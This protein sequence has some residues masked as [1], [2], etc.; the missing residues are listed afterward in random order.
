MRRSD[1]DEY[2]TPHAHEVGRTP[3]GGPRGAARVPV[4][5]QTL[6]VAAVGV[7][8]AVGLTG[9]IA[10]VRGAGRHPEAAVTAFL[11][12]QTAGDFAA[13][14]LLLSA[15]DRDQPRTAAGWRF[16]HLCTSPT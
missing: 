14:Y 16:A 11:D 4:A 5:V 12:A 13:S 1:V 3:P 6:L 2:V 10:G 9:A 15:A 8:L 7:A